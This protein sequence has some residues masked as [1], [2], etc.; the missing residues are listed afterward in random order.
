MMKMKRYLQLSTRSNTCAGAELNYFQQ[1]R[2]LKYLESLIVQTDCIPSS[3]ETG[4][5]AVFSDVRCCGF[6]CFR[7]DMLLVFCAGALLSVDASTSGERSP[8]QSVGS[9]NIGY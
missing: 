5:S 3:E 1:E 9:V 7:R 8:Q 4:V 6:A 2:G